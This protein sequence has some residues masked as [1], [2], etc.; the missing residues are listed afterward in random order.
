MALARQLPDF[1]FEFKT[2]NVSYRIRHA[3]QTSFRPANEASDG[4]AAHTLKCERISSRPSQSGSSR[5][6]KG[7]NRESGPAA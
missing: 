1:R 7:T 4:R 5:R 3:I 6:A 2:V